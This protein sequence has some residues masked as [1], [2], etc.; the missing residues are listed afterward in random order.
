MIADSYSGFLPRMFEWVQNT[1]E[2]HK[3]DRRSVESFGFRRLPV[4][5]TKTLLAE[6][7]VVIVDRPPFPPVSAWGLSEF[8]TFEAHPA[9]AITF[10]DTYF[11][12]PR[13]AANESV[14]FHELIHVI[15]WQELGFTDFMMLYV[16]GILEHG[17]LDAPLEK[18]AYEHERRFE[19]GGMEYAVAEAV[20]REATALLRA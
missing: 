16:A 3:H 13:A 2:A 10:L 11:I 5:F 6:T 12:T 20:R 1:L 19:L 7:S 17:Y 14:H 9:G 18:M 15:Q 8:A 4:Y